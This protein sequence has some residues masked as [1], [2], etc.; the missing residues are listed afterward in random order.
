[1]IAAD[2]RYF[3]LIGQIRESLHLIQQQT[4]VDADLLSDRQLEPSY[5]IAA[6]TGDTFD[7]VASPRQQHSISLTGLPQFLITID[8]GF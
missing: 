6:L 5:Q 1:M 4:T 7:A 8:A 2:D 3:H